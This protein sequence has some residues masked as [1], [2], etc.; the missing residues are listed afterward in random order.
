MSTHTHT[1]AILSPMTSITLLG[2]CT[3]RCALGVYAIYLN[4][5]VHT[6]FPSR[7][8]FSCCLWTKIRLLY[9][10]YIIPN[11]A[12]ILPQPCTIQLL[13]VDDNQIIVYAIYYTQVCTH[14]SPVMLRSAVACGRQSDYCVRNKFI[15]RCAHIIPQPCT[16]QLL[17]VDDN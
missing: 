4:P 7:A 14:P 5:S 13:L 1:Q 17:L 9:T 6:S 12:H 8:P 3:F 11:C 2:D 15:R 10:Q 16:V